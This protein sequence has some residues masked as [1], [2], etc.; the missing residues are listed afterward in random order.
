[1]EYFVSYCSE[2]IVTTYTVH[3]YIINSERRLGEGAGTQ[4]CALLAT[5]LLVNNI[6]GS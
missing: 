6:D 5:S 3:T 2:A 4:E 1:M